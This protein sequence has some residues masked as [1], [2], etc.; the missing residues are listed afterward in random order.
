MDHLK[1]SME[2]DNWQKAMLGGLLETRVT[3]VPKEVEA[4][5]LPQFYKLLERGGSHLSDNFLF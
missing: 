4:R 3:S 2:F 5:E 1:P